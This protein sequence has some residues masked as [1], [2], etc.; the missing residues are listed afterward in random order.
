[1]PRLTILS[2]SMLGGSPATPLP[3]TEAD[4][5]FTATDGPT[6]L[7]TVIVTS[8]TVV[9][10]YNTDVAAHDISFASVM[11]SFNRS[12]DISN[13]SVAAGKVSC[14]GP[15]QASGFAQPGTG[16]MLFIDISDPKLRIAVVQL[17]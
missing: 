5:I 10:A 12:G 9:L 11:D 7:Q 3:A 6:S 17:P 16:N 13:Y 15:F 14:F 2:Q 1:M 4:L 8:K